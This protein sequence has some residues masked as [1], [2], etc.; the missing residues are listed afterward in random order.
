MEMLPASGT[1][2]TVQHVEESGLRAEPTIRFMTRAQ[3]ATLWAELEAAS[4]LLEG[5]PGAGKSTAVWFWLTQRVLR[6]GEKALWCHFMKLGFWV[7][8]VISRGEDGKL[9]FKKINARDDPFAHVYDNEEKIEICVVDG[10]THDNK[11]MAGKSWRSFGFDSSLY[12]HC[13]M[14]WI[15][16]QQLVVPREHLHAVN[17]K[18]LSLY[19]W[20]ETEINEYAATFDDG[21]KRAFVDEV[22]AGIPQ[23][24]SLPS[25]TIDFEQACTIKKYFCG[26]SA[27]WMFG[28]SLKDALEDIEIHLWKVNNVQL[29]QNGLAGVRGM[30]AVNHVFA[31]YPS[32]NSDRLGLFK[33]SS[34]FMMEKISETVGLEA[35]RA[36]YSSHWVQNN[37]SV[38]GFVFEWDIITQLQKNNSLTLT[39][40]SL[41]STWTI[42]KT[43]RLEEFLRHGIADDEQLLVLP[44]KWN[45]PEYDGLYIYKDGDRHLHLVAWNASEAA[46]HSGSVS[47]LLVML[48]SLSQRE[49]ESI[50]FDTVRFLFLVPHERLLNFKMPPS[51]QCLLAKQQLTAWSF[52][53]FE[54]GGTARTQ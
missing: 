25:A 8:R 23:N 33:I 22:M 10:V 53:G 2:V 30:T 16:S 46:T 9:T 41:E 29:I 40:G 18:Y 27:R 39:V 36:M 15:S 12:K 48:E 45:H 28:M 6:T 20:T 1:V 26:C 3:H 54:V 35:I 4:C 13:H 24:R 44:E 49:A 14:I 47:K 31:M 19:S 38:H 52:G 32:N 37:P 7:V 21:M 43:V 51:S 42:T 17:M 34:S 11:E 50:N 5:P